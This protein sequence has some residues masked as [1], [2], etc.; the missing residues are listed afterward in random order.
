M[1]CFETRCRN[2]NFFASINFFLI[3]YFRI[4]VAYQRTS[5]FNGDYSNSYFAF[6]RIWTGQTEQDYENFT[7]FEPA[8]PNISFAR[9]GQRSPSVQNFFQ[10]FW[11][12]N[13]GNNETNTAAG[14][15][16]SRRVPVQNTSSSSLSAGTDESYI[17][18]V[19][20]KLNGKN[21][22]FHI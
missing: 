17:K 6:E 2:L 4:F 5:I 11:Q 14:S 22:T 10:R 8:I 18:K 20:L 19:V 13:S 1:E 15:L 16:N 12:R 3:F 21:K 7:P 9:Q